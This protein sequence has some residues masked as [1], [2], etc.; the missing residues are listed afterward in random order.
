MDNLGE[1]LKK[2]LSDPQSMQQVEALANSL[3]LTGESAQ[4]EPVS[5]PAT[6]PPTPSGNQGLDPALLANLMG[7]LSQGSQNPGSALLSPPAAPPPVSGITPELL[8]MVTRLAPMLS[9]INQEDDST[10]LL[11]ALRPLLG[12]T[13]QKKVD[14]AM[15]ILQ[16]MR[17]LPVLKESGIFSGLLSGLL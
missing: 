4:K 3:G 15:K 5:A 9:R 13:R 6:S 8:G 10:R 7:A 16:M 12:P 1:E 11:H 2:F 14:E 17:L